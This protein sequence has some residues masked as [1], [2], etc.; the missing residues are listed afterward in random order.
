MIIWYLIHNYYPTKIKIYNHLFPPTYVEYA[1]KTWLCYLLQDAHIIL[2]I[3]FPDNMFK[4]KIKQAFPSP[5]I[6]PSFARYVECLVTW[7]EGSRLFPCGAVTSLF[8]VP[9]DRHLS[10]CSSTEIDPSSDSEG[11]HLVCFVSIPSNPTTP[12]CSGCLGP[13]LLSPESTGRILAFTWER[14]T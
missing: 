8:V 7:K 14:S 6:P 1:F 2:L 3:S 10:V 11:N 9:R 13:P 5:Q 4:R 12:L